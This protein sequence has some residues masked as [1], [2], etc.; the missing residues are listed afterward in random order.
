M[1][2]Y[3]VIDYAILMSAQPAIKNCLKKQ[4]K[5]ILKYEEI[6]ILI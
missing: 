6:D 2:K 4:Y 1:E 3:I 5:S